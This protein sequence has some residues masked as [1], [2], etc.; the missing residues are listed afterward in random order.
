MW[1]EG[2]TTQ[3]PSQLYTCAF[4]LITIFY[5]RER[6]C[7]GMQVDRGAAEG[8]GEGEGERILSRL[9]AVEPDMGLDLMTVRS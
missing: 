4:I 6:V 5:F 7:A 2:K 1:T 8:E 9:H 3:G